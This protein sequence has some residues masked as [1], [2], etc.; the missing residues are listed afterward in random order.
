MAKIRTLRFLY[1]TICQEYFYAKDNFVAKN[2]IRH[3]EA[4]TYIPFR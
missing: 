2:I 1:L 4:D 3:E